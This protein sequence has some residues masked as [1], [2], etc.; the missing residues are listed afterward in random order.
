MVIVIFFHISN[1]LGA[2]LYSLVAGLGVGGIAIAL[3]AQP[4]IENFIG[5]LNLFADHPVRVGDFCRF[6]EDPTIDWKRIGTVESIGLRSTRIRGIDHTVTTIP[7]AD[8][9][10]MQIIN[11]SMRKNILCN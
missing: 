5:S 9:S 6:G 8:F 10:K 11:Y 1:R 3:A 4:T 7:N 2:P